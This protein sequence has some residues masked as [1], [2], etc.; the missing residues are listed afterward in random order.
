MKQPKPKTKAR[1]R[2]LPAMGGLT[3]PFRPGEIKEWRKAMDL[4]QDQTAK[5]FGVSVRTI[6]NWEQGV[7]SPRPV[8]GVRRQMREMMGRRS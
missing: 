3:D 4:T 8:F 7:S 2:A 5:L 6:E 1:K